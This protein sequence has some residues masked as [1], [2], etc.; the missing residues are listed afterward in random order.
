MTDG[1]RVFGQASSSTKL[2]LAADTVVNNTD[3]TVILASIPRT[4]MLSVH[5]DVTL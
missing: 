5:H 2:K 4:D 1:H 3:A